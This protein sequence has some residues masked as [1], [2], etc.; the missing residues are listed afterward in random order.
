MS[1]KE[2]YVSPEIKVGYFDLKILTS[3]GE[4]DEERY[5]NEINDAFSL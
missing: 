4:Q 2:K 5:D 3:S 1:T